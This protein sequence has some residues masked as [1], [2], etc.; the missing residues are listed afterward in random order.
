MASDENYHF[1]LLHTKRIGLFDGQEQLLVQNIKRGV[2]RQ[3]ESV[4]T[5]VSSGK[6]IWFTPFF[7]AKLPR[8]YRAPQS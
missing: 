8:S 2:R 1:E 3:I 6:T 4:E 7:Y 5:R